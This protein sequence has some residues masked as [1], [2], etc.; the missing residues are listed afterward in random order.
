MAQN[1]TQKAHGNPAGVGTI[2]RCPVCEIE[3]SND[4]IEMQMAPYPLPPDP[5]MAFKTQFV[6]KG[7][8]SLLPIQMTFIPG[9]LETMLNAINTALGTGAVDP[10]KPLIK[11]PP[12]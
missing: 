8:G 1:P 3:M 12:A 6:C 11:W 7:C 5:P 9:V 10:G 4:K 2:P